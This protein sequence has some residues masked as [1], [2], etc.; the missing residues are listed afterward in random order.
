MSKREKQTLSAE[1]ERDLDAIDT[2][3]RGETVSCERAALA[4]LALELSALRPQPTAEFAAS[5]DERAARGFQRERRVRSLPWPSPVRS[6][7]SGRGAARPIRRHPAFALAALIVVAVAVVAVPPALRGGAAQH[8]STLA[9]RS[10]LAPQ[11][12]SAAAG[13]S[14]NGKADAQAPASSPAVSGAGTAGL[15]SEA[16]APG[17]RQIE[18]GVTLDIGLAPSS[19]EST[20]RQV[21]ALV[22]VF[23]GYVQQSN[24]SSGEAEQNAGATFQLRLPSAD[25]TSAIAAL[26]HL[27]R[28]RSENDTTNDVTAQFDALR[29]SLQ[30]A[31]AER[32]SVLKQL[33]NTS[34]QRQAQ[35][36]KA[37]LRALEAHIS[38]HRGALG[39]L[40]GRIDY[41]TV[42]LSLTPEAPRNGSAGVLTPG[43][44][45][46][47]AARVL[48][49]GFAVLILASAALV[50][51]AAI[52]MLAWIFLT[53]MRRRLREQA[54][55]GH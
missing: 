9:P 51:L 6:R 37:R 54:L 40:T 50:P 13:A 32:S 23:H 53:I 45:A 26:S 39:A 46:S 10:A 15:E 30:D 38:Q 19:I 33:G 24:V 8:S 42:A 43:A 17:A 27:G 55:G 34:E 12:A 7:W 35:A 29:R 1:A 14:P 22:S 3:L 41:T 25:L 21:F 47:A 28:V 48:A 31:Q 18:R 49:A 36:L 20:S 11:A 44:A 4:E 5:L 52:V 2:A 16:A